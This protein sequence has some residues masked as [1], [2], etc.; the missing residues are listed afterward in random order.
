MKTTTPI[1]VLIWFVMVAHSPA[2]SLWGQGKNPL[3]RDFQPS[4]RAVQS[5]ESGYL[6]EQ[7]R[8]NSARILPRQYSNPRDPA[9]ETKTSFLKQPSSRS[10]E[11][12]NEL[13]P[14]K[15]DIE[16]KKSELKNKIFDKSFD[17]GVLP[18]SPT[19]SGF[20]N[21]ANPDRGV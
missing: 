11:S 10:N 18:P 2:Q 19:N 15:Y 21:K 9:P 12:K 5:P 7:N 20:P 6:A 13:D 1:V 4:N 17:L 16:P 14:P 3:R 8:M